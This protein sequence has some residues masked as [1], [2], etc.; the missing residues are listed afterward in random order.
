MSADLDQ[1]L[2]E[3]AIL[4]RW[5]STGPRFHRNVHG[6]LVELTWREAMVIGIAMGELGAWC[7]RVGRLLACRERGCTMAG[8]FPLFP[9]SSV[10]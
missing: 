6:A 9:G 1:L 8:H 4:L 3:M 5:V 10:R 7:Q 2:E